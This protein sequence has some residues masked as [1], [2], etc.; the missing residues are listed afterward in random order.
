MKAA[1]FTIEDVAAGF[2]EA[3]GIVSLE[4]D[5][6]RLQWA[7]QDSVFGVF[8]SANNEVR[9]PLDRLQSVRYVPGWWRGR[10]VLRADDLATLDGIPGADRG[11]VVLMVDR[12]ERAAAAELA[13]DANFRTA[14]ARVH[15][16]LGV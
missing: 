15:E 10:L 5:A 12:A 8:K 1:R 11:E 6:I 13:I 14:E 9:I 16:L 7:V 3:R 4:G 2:A